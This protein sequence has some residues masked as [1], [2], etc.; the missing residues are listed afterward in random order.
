MSK[1]K[2]FDGL[3]AMSLMNGLVFFAPV[4]L[5]VRTRVGISVEQFFVLQAVLSIV[6]F[7]FE[8]PTG[9]I[10]DKVG[11]RNTIIFSQ[12]TLCA[13]RVLLFVAFMKGSLLV[14][15]AEAVIEGIA[16]CFASGTQ[17]A[18]LYTTMDEDEFV[19][20]TARV[21]NCGTAGFIISTISYAGM[22]SLWGL[23]GLLIATIVSSGIG[24]LASFRI[25]K[26]NSISKLE[27]S[28]PEP[29]PLRAFFGTIC[30]GKTLILVI[31][32]S[33]ISIG[34]VLINFFY[35]DK[36][37]MFDIREELLTPIILGY[38]AVQL[39]AEKIL[40]KIENN[41]YFRTFVITFIFAGIVLI[42]FGF[43]SNIVLTIVLMLVLP[44]LLDLPAYILDE[45]QNKMIDQIELRDKRAELL[46][47]FNMGVNIV[48]IVF[49][50][51]SAAL[52]KMG[53]SICFN[54]LGVLMIVMSLCF[55]YIFRQRK[56]HTI[57][58]I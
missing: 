47:V 6:I 41:K 10:T 19:V 48:E 11:Y 42:C 12:I 44:L 39:L 2:K 49:L 34:F 27:A 38:S 5:L 7:L 24:I 4:A 46:S 15:I 29:M 33:C 31:V 53:I 1:K 18:Y 57:E 26:E 58:H 52:S 30:N 50:F 21:S 3:D 14:F 20:K 8:I 36:L 25:K 37:Q 23:K 9:K 40:G 22:Y 35:V 17:S 51:S 28:S 54:I 32:L 16:C 45:I 55:L 56:I 13:A 43:T